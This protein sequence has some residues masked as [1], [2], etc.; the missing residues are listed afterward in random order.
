M[1]EPVKIGFDAKIFNTLF[2]ELREANTRFVINYGGAGSG[3]SFT[4]TQFEIIKCLQNKENILVIRKYATTLKNSVIKLFLSILKSWSIP[5][6]WRENKTDRTI[7]FLNDSY[8][9]FSGLDDPEK[10]K[11]IAGITRIWVEEATELS[12]DEFNQLNLRLRGLDDLQITL[13]FNPVDEQHWLKKYFFDTETVRAK[14]TIIKTTYLDNKFIDQAY[15][16]ELKSYKEID[17]NYYKIYALGDWGGITEGRIFSVWETI[18]EFPF[19]DGYWFGLDFGYSNDPTAIVKVILKNE[20]LYIDEICYSKGLV[21]SEIANTLKAEGYAGEPVIC[22]AAEPK[23]IQELRYFGV[24]AIAADKRQGSINAGIDFLKRTKIKVTS[25]S[26]NIQNENRFYQWKQDKNG[27]FINQP[28]DVFNHSIDAI[29]YSVSL[30]LFNDKKQ[31][32]M[33]LEYEHL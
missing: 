19:A 1:N 24:N 2:W 23:S 10:I 28:K 15:K 18:P 14:T 33:F 11:S 27:N 26:K 29:R 3:K 20:V 16:E 12:K 17:E 31:E 13:T 32:S 4:Q 21:N 9:V 8:I 30:Y 5:H 25:R 7:T 22:D 6:L